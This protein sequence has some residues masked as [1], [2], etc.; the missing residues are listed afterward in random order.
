MGHIEVQEETSNQNMMISKNS[1]KA[2][3]LNNNL[4]WEKDKKKEVTKG[5]I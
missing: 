3:Y 2:R 5:R 1:F 4:T